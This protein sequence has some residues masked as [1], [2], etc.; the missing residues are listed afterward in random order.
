MIKFLSGKLNTKIP[1]EVLSNFNKLKEDKYLD[2][3]HC[4]RFRSFSEFEIKKGE[5]VLKQKRDFYQKSEINHYAGNISRRFEPINKE[6]L[7]TFIK[8]SKELITHLPKKFQN[9]SDIGAHQIRIKCSNNFVGYPV[10]EGWHKDMCDYVAIISLNYKNIVGGT[11]RIRENLNDQN[12]I[13]NTFLKKNNFL[14][15]NEKFFYHYTDPINIK[16]KNNNGFR[17]IL[18]LTING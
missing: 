9:F 18:V 15:L 17:D 6:C 1:N 11:S 14:L 5:I 2:A 7:K 3:K 12:D 16:N 8:I 10:P 4:Y 13:Y